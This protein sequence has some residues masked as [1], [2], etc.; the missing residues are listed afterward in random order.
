MC[1]DNQRLARLEIA[2]STLL[3]VDGLERAEATDDY[4]L[5]LGK[6]LLDDTEDTVNGLESC[7]EVELLGN[8]NLFA[9]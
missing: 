6:R 2:C 3:V 7:R 9:N 5:A 1:R 8:R 4:R